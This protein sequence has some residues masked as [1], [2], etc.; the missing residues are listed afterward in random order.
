MLQDGFKNKHV[1]QFNNGCMDLNI[2][3][4]KHF[5][6]LVKSVCDNNYDGSISYKSIYKF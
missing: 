5:S 1:T 2:K 3:F 4:T 6:L